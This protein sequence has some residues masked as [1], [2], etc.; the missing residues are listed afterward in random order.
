MDGVCPGAACPA[1]IVHLRSLPVPQAAAGL[2]R[3]RHGVLRLG[4]R[5]IARAQAHPLVEL[6]C[7]LPLARPV[8]RHQRVVP[9]EA[10]VAFDGRLLLKVVEQLER[11]LPLLA[12]RARRDGAAVAEGVRRLRHWCTVGAGNCDG[13][14]ATSRRG[15]PVGRA[16][17]AVCI[18]H[19]AAVAG[20]EA[21]CGQPYF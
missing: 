13:A 4:Q 5:A 16:Q 14:P 17:C 9:R 20:E 19:R 10:R 12:E 3:A 8:A 2:H 7:A 21:L 15:D 1:A 6:E 11:A 18:V